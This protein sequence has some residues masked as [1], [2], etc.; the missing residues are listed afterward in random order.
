M[1]AISGDFESA[2]N[3]LD[4]V[5]LPLEVSRPRIFYATR[6]IY[7]KTQVYFGPAS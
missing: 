4:K 2:D 3:L 6:A 1:S 5:K 7:Q